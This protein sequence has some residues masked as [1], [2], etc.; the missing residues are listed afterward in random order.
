[1]PQD[2]KILNR[3]VPINFGENWV[4]AEYYFYNYFDLRNVEKEDYLWNN[5][6]SE[7]IY[8]HVV[9]SGHNILNLSTKPKIGEKYFSRFDELM[10]FVY[11][12]FA[13]E[14]KYIQYTIDGQ[15]YIYKVFAVFFEHEYLIDLE[16]ED[17]Y[18]KK[19]TKEYIKQAKQS[20]IY[21]YDV[22]I[23]ENDKL[24][25]LTTCT[26]F[27]GKYNPKQIIVVGRQLREKEKMDNYK[28]TTNEKYE[29]IRNIMEGDDKNA[30]A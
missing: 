24:I 23:N 30:Q 19:Q 22:D 11:E 21:D 7:K 3:L 25:T 14:N 9:V 15:D 28:V 10:A 26:R 18:T 2:Y 17:N 16:P 1:M 29:E 8:N 6:N 27:Y 13:E 5:N 4:W 12:D 20:T